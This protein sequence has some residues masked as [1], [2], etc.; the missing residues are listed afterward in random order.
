MAGDE[1]F[2]SWRRVL[3]CLANVVDAFKHDD[4]RDA[5]LR[6]CVALEAG[7]GIDAGNNGANVNFRRHIR[8]AQDSVAGDCRIHDPHLESLR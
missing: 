7:Q 1:V 3:P 8:F 6:E 5:R 4:M 2:S